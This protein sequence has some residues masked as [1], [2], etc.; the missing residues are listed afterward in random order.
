MQISQQL[1]EVDDSKY[2]HDKASLIFQARLNKNL[3]TY[4]QH[5]SQSLKI[6]DCSLVV[7]TVLPLAQDQKHLKNYL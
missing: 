2:L 5:Q 3:V 1:E 4:P 7:V 6:M